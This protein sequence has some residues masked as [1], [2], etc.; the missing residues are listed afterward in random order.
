MSLDWI[1]QKGV[2]ESFRTLPANILNFFGLRISPDG[3]RFAIR[4]KQKSAKIW[5]YDIGRGSGFPLTD[6]KGNEYWAVWTPDNKSVIFTSNRDG[7]PFNLYR[8]SADGSGEPERLTEGKDGKAVYSI[9]SDGKIAAFLE[10]TDS[11][12][13]DLWILPL[14]GDRDPQIFLRTPHDEF[15]PAISPDG[16][17]LAYTSNSSGQ[18][19][20]YVR[21]YPGPGGFI[22]ISNN[23]GMAPVWHPVLR[24]L[25]YCQE[26][27]MMVVTYKTKPTFE[28]GIPEQLFES[29]HLISSDKWGRE[30]DLS[31]D[32]Q[33][34][35][36]IKDNY[37]QNATREIHVVVNWFEELKEKIAAAE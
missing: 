13:L 28:P 37:I 35:L 5:I 18:N 7:E 8:M 33:R 21:P 30:Y 19:E 15:H 17:W 10:N 23:G 20:V 12:G 4:R 31:P 3:K 6:D 16:H 2:T 26:K 24:E 11:T 22:T 25:F 36:M 32:G 1:N 14:Q 34:F 29:D 9:S 27:K